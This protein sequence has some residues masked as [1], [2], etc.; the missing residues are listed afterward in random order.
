MYIYICTEGCWHVER[1]IYKYSRN[2]PK[3]KAGAAAVV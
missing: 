1:D 3:P 2:V